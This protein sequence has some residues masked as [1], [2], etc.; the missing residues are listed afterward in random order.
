MIWMGRRRSGWLLAFGP[1]EAEAFHP[2]WRHLSSGIFG[3][4][5]HPM[6][7]PCHG[8]SVSL[9]A[10]S[11]ATFLGNPTLGALERW[12]LGPKFITALTLLT[13]VMSGAQRYTVRLEQVIYFIII[14]L[15]FLFFP[16]IFFCF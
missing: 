3:G 13:F 1:V 5:V 14:Y 12:R 7:Q 6:W 9:S 15:F 4:T 11:R 2:Q 8:S 10:G 16:L